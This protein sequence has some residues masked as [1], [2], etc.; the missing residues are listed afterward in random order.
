LKEK[1]E[2]KFEKEIPA[3]Y[4]EDAKKYRADAC[5]KNRQ[6]LMMT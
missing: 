5:R 3:E 4:L 2:I 1:W 6:N